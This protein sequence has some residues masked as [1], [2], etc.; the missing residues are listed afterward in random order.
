M[1]RKWFQLVAEDGNTLTSADAVSVDIEDVAALRHAVKEVFK[2]SHLAGIAASDL[3]VFDANGV[4]LG[5]RDSLA[6]IDEKVTLLVQVPQRAEIAPT[7]FILPETRERVAKAVFVI[8]EEDKDDNG[9]G[10]GVLKGVGIGVF[11]SA[12]LAVTCDHN[13]TEQNTVGSS[14]SLALKDEMVDVVVVARNAELDFAILKSSQPRSFI[15][16]WNGSTDDLESCCDLVLASFRLGIDEY[17]ARYK[18][19]LPIMAWC[20]Q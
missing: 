14:V 13:L 8:V 1:A 6:H 5:P 18:A 2:D 15:A 9:V 17:Q 7:Y 10:M 19:G 4:A 11:F 20:L 16:P 12:T 3:T